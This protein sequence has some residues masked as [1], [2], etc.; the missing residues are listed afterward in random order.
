M[1]PS[2]P[3][4]YGQLAALEAAGTGFVLVVLVEALGSTPQ[5]TGAKML[6][7]PQGLIT[8]TVGGGRVEAQAITL[9]QEILARSGA[10]RTQPAFVSWTLKGDVGMT[11]GGSVKLYFEPHAGAAGSWPIAIFGAGHVAQA[12]LRVLTPL[13]CTLTVCDSRAEWLDQ[14]PTARNLRVVPLEQ[15]AE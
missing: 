10:D 15:P 11:C 7:G 3:T 4:F 1:S 12:L 2:A 6:V 5:D 9:A 8:G 14:L 13:P